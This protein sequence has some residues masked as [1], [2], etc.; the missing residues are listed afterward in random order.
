M[1]KSPLTEHKLVLQD[2]IRTPPGERLVRT[3]AA[4]S[5]RPAGQ[6]SAKIAL[7]PPIDFYAPFR[8]HRLSWRGTQDVLVAAAGGPD[9]DT[10]SAFGAE[11]ESV[12]V[13][14]RLGVPARP[15]LLLQRAE[16]K[17]LRVAPQPDVPGEVIEE[18]GDGALSGTLTWSGSDGRERSI[19]LAALL[20]RGRLGGS[21]LSSL[22]ETE[23]S[24]GDETALL[25]CGS[26]WGMSV[27]P[28]D[29][30]ILK[31]ARFEFLDGL[32]GHLE[33]EL[34]TQYR[35]PAG[36]QERVTLRLEGVT[37]DD[38]ED[39]NI[40][41]IFRRIPEGVTSEY[42]RINVVEDDPIDD[43]D[44]GTRNFFFTDNGEIRSIID[45]GAVFENNSKS[46]VLLV[47]ARKVF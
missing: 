16:R 33:I 13:D 19:P 47:W 18:P 31:T 25:P 2:F 5:G 3:A 15:I 46:D 35:T 37:P 26:S 30:T 24:C 45:P 8:E 32:S 14:A 36:V 42:I 20:R 23:S 28:A 1:R 17:S 44:K 22:D 21:R 29:T 9:A 10:A 11:G 34:R 12:I 43:D 38:W 4:R 40:P 7:L 41:L 6:L 39:Y 27:Q